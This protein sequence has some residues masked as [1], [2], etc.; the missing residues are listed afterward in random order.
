[1]L[2]AFSPYKGKCPIG[3]R[4]QKNKIIDKKSKNQNALPTNKR[5]NPKVET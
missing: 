5:Y 4:G 2:I 1:M 3:Q